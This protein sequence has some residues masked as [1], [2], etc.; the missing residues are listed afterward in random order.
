MENGYISTDEEVIELLKK[1]LAGPHA[2]G[3]G[4]SMMSTNIDLALSRAIAALE[5]KKEKKDEP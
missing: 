2:R 4:K 5:E 3:N 1:I